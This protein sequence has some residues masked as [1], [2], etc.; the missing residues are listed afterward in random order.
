MSNPFLPLFP[1]KPEGWSS[2]QTS[3]IETLEKI[4]ASTFQPIS[5][6]PP[7]LEPEKGD[8]RFRDPDWE[9]NP[10]F[11][12]VQQIYLL[13]TRYWKEFLED[14]FPADDRKREEA[15]FYLK[16]FSDAMAPTNFPWTN[17]EVV[18]ET[19]KEG[20]DNFV[21]GM[22]NFLNDQQEKKTW[23]L[24]ASTDFSAFG[25]GKNLAI[26]PGHV[27]FENKLCQLITYIPLTE[28][29]CARPLLIVPP[30]INK[31][32]IFDLNPQNSFVRWNLEQ[33]RPVFMLS[34]ANPDS[35][36]RD[37]SFEDYLFDA[38]D[39]CIDVVRNLSGQPTINILGFCVSGVALLSLLSLHGQTKTK[40]VHSATLL[41]TPVDFRHLKEFSVFVSPQQLRLLEER[42]KA[43]G[44]LA[45]EHMVRLFASLRANDLIWS[46]YVN[47]Y[48]LGKTP[49]HFDFLFWNSDTTNL[50]GK[51]HIEYLREFFLKN[52]F[53]EKTS[54]RIRGFHP[55]LE[56]ID[57]PLFSLGTKGD[58]IVPWK[59]AYSLKL[60]KPNVEFVLGNSGHIAGIM[61]P[62]ELKKYNY[63]TLPQSENL[64]PDAWMGAA[65]SFEGSW[66]EYWNQWMASYDGDKGPAMKIAKDQIIESAPGRYVL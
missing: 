60:K 14:A 41:A 28:K 4:I 17:P 40:K 43:T 24:P 3:Y 9:K 61:N 27:V 52:A 12:Y 8:R 51:M 46:N 35:S 57:V 10:F 39:A 42:V 21:K 37:V 16:S 44:V 20:G 65:T 33:G 48:L 58:H 31:F 7:V 30:W 23:G 54:Y 53:C 62:P 22:Q 29:T 32:Y 6:D 49:P 19:L 25:V 11:R 2:L 26:T 47:N 38:I 64:D 18:R 50:A 45:G 59:A 66:W 56:A 36:F 1:E 15:L 34:W 5:K 55:S 63:W 13:N